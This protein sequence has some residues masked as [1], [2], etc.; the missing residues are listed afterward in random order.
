MANTPIQLTTTSASGQAENVYPYAKPEFIIF[1][2]NKTLSDK[3]NNIGN[4]HSHSKATVSN[5]GYMSKE[6]KAKLDG[7]TN[8]T[9]PSTHAASMI[10]QDAN[11]RFVTDT[12]KSTWNAKA[13][14][15]VATSSTNGLLSKEDKQK[16]DRISNNFD[17]VYDSSTETINF[18]FR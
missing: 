3:M 16:I 9:H 17:L 7:I 12:E 4:T 1:S 14:T 18:R 6:D 2:D 11:N 8:Y 10:T 13:S 5:D 15:A